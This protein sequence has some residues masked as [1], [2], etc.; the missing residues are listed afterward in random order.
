M[1][2]TMPSPLYPST[3]DVTTTRVLLLTKL[4][5]HRSRL[6]CSPPEC[7]YRSNLR[8]LTAPANSSRLQ[9][10]CRTELWGAMVFC[11]NWSGGRGKDCTVVMGEGDDCWS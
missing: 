11:S 2:T 5:M 6:V 3:V 7:A 9:S 10:H 1:L 8:A 4:R